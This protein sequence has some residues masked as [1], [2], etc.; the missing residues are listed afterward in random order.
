M[1]LG[2]LNAHEPAARVDASHFDLLQVLGQGSFGR[3]FLV[4]KRTGADA[5]TLYAMKVL[6]KATLK[7]AGGAPACWPGGRLGCQRCA[8]V[9]AAAA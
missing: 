9:G 7:G 6:R 4:R 1:E 3:V 2:E 8:C 5:D